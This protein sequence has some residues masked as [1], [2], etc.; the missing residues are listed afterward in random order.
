M[1]CSILLPKH[2]V[3]SHSRSPTILDNLRV[4]CK[5]GNVW[6]RDGKWSRKTEMS[7]LH[8]I[9]LLLILVAATHSL[10]LEE[11][12]SSKDQEQEQGL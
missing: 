9:C 11:G 6:P 3:S 5:V 1:A 10:V 7:V 2:P 8:E 4:A 12:H